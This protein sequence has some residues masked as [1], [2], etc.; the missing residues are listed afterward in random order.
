[1]AGPSLE[2][3]RS[4]RQDDGRGMIL[5]RFLPSNPYEVAVRMTVG[6]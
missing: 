1:M 4:G 6:G 5:M 3:L 2:S